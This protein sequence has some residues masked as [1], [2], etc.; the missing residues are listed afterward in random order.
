MKPLKS[1]QKWLGTVLMVSLLTT[2]CASDEPT[3]TAPQAVEVELKTL[4][5]ATL[6]DSST[7]VGTL[8]ARQR[9]Q[10]APSRTNG[11][12]KQILVREGDLV[13]QG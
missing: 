8:E 2:G 3:A 7:Y 5:P 11:R 1:S 12:I 4:K 9:V 10:L 13:R 6:V